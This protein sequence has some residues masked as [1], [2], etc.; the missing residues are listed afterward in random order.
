VH[1]QDAKIKLL[2]SFYYEYALLRL[3]RKFNHIRSQKTGFEVNL[4]RSKLYIY[5]IKEI[6]RYIN[7]LKV[8]AART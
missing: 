6:N 3:P 8:K 2:L 7:K 1:E 4:V 5:Y